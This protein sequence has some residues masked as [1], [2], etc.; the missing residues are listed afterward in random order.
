VLRQL[1]SVTFTQVASAMVD[2]RDERLGDLTLVAPDKLA[3]LG[4][5]GVAGNGTRLY[6]PPARADPQPMT[7]SRAM[8]LWRWTWAT[9]LGAMLVASCSSSASNPPA[10][11]TPV[12]PPTPLWTGRGPPT[13]RHPADVPPD[14]AP[15]DAA[16]ERPP[17]CAT[18]PPDINTID[19]DVGGM[20]FDGKRR[21]LYA[22]VRN[23]PLVAVIDATTRRV[24]ATLE[25]GPTPNRLG[26]SDDQ[27]TLWISVEGEGSAF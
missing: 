11:G 13:G 4:Y 23:T 9:A 6:F 3:M 14:L 25:A 27:S 10:G 7:R 24:T 19:L 26:L 5:R 20:V 2:I 22:S 12:R 16:A 15:A 18:C 1:E 21:R 17:L 8:D